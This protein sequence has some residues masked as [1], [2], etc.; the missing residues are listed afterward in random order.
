M[1][2]TKNFRSLGGNPEHEVQIHMKEIVEFRILEKYDLPRK[3]H[4][5]NRLACRAPE[6]LS[7]IACCG[8]FCG[9]SRWRLIGQ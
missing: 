2:S 6:V 7:I 3:F 5:G 9:V 1:K 8:E 4:P